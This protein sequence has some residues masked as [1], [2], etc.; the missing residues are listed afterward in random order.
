VAKNS[1]AAEG[2]HHGL[3]F[4]RFQQHHKFDAR[5]KRARLAGQLEACGITFEVAVDQQ[6]VEWLIRQ[7][8][9]CVRGAACNGDSG[10]AA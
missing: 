8:S 1:P 5:V 3:P 10:K 7:Q 6:N 9:H 4:R 2:L